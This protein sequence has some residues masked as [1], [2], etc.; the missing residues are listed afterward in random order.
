MSLK[1]SRALIDNATIIAVGLTTSLSIASM[2]T[3]QIVPPLPKSSLAEGGDRV[4]AFSL[5][6]GA[7]VA[8]YMCFEALKGNLNKLDGDDILAKYKLWFENQ[9]LYQYDQFKTGYL[10]EMKNFNS[11]IAGNYCKFSL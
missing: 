5:G 1:L 10:L 3:A 8:N 7:G 2:A 11:T 9:D 6:Y 4:G